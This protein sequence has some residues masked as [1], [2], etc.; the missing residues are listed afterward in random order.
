MRVPAAIAVC[1][2]LFADLAAAQ[3]LRLVTGT[4]YA[5]YADASLPHGGL[6]T[7]IVVRAFDATGIDVLVN[8]EPWAEGFALTRDG[9][10][11]ATFP[12]LLVEERQEHFVYSQPIYDVRRLL[13]SSIRNPIEPGEPG[14]F[15]GLVLCVPIGYALHQDLLR[16]VTAGD[17]IV[18]RP[19]TMDRCIGEIE[20]GLSDFVVVPELIAIG[21][22]V[23]HGHRFSDFHL[24]SQPISR[25]AYYLIVSRAAGNADAIVAGFNRGLADLR[26]GG[27]YED[28]ISR[29]ID[30]FI[31]SMPSVD[32]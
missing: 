23:G 20:R 17:L 19:A 5:P 28:L 9:A 30:E 1:L 29:R 25:D 16:H 6:A 18:R 4:D 15:A 13:L 21:M 7:E 11:A 22:I 24:S 27:V 10:Y 2:V 14:A 32:R 3:E 26:R 8:H 31:G 12:Y